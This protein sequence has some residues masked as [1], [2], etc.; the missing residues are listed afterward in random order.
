MLVGI[1]GVGRQHLAKL[2]GP[3]CPLIGVGTLLIPYAVYKLIIG[4]IFLG[5]GLLVLYAVSAV[6][7]QLCEPRIVGKSLGLHPLVT[8]I[9]TYVG[10][11]A[12]GFFGMIAAPFVAIAIS[13]AMKTSR[14][15]S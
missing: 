6:T 5:I 13:A 12:L 10:L 9:A 7:R 1:V 4:D 11:K 15:Q 8:L 3:S 14:T 2:V